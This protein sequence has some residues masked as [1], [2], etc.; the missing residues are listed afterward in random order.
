MDSHPW[1]HTRPS[2]APLAQLPEHN[3]KLLTRENLINILADFSSRIFQL[4]Q[5][6]I[7][8]V[9]HGGAVMLLH[10]GLYAQP[11]SSRRATRDVDY[12]HR[13]FVEEWRRVGMHDAEAKLQSC[14]YAT[15]QKFQLGTDWMNAHADVALPMAQ[16]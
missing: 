15:A 11:G 5:S 14:I 3:E 7:R 13:S 10:P 4:F 8:L 9:V 16:E 6:P 2:T 12:I 1:S